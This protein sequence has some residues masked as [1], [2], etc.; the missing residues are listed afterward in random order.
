MEFRNYL[1][2]EER[3]EEDMPK[4]LAELTAGFGMFRRIEFNGGYTMSIQASRG[5]YSHPR[6]VLDDKYDYKSFEVALMN[7]RG[8]FINF[9]DEFGIDFLEEFFDGGVIY[10][11]APVES[12]QKVFDYMANRFGIVPSYDYFKPQD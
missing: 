5:H 8:D 3:F 1:I 4:H 6:E 12:I 2:R 7:S 9:K 11:Y 10:G